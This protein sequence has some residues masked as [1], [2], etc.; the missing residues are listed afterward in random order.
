[1]VANQVNATS[2]HS[3]HGL[4]SLDSFAFHPTSKLRQ[5]TLFGAAVLAQQDDQFTN[6]LQHTRKDG[7][8][9][10]AHQRKKNN[11]L[12]TNKSKRDISKCKQIK[13]NTKKTAH[14]LR[15]PFP[16][17]ANADDKESV[18]LAHRLHIEEIS[19]IMK[20]KSK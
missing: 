18:A 11:R 20:M 12:A 13:A 4:P 5:V 17:S 19:A 7:T 2:G 10:H 9:V 1:M 3:F 15:L 14:K 16:M 8:M 6:V